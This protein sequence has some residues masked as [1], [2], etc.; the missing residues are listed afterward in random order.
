MVNLVTTA[1]AFKNKYSVNSRHN[2]SPGWSILRCLSSLEAGCWMLFDV[3]AV[4]SIQFMYVEIS[5]I[6][7]FNSVMRAILI[8]LDGVIYDSKSQIKGA[9]ETISWLDKSSIPYL[10]VTNTCS[11]PRQAIVDKL[12]AM[13]IN[14]GQDKI[15]TPIVA[16]RQWLSEHN[17]EPIA[18][19]LEPATMNEFSDFQV[20]EQSAE[21]GA[22][23]VL[24]GDIGEAWNYHSLNRALRL[25]ISEPKPELIALGM[26]RYWHSEHGLALDVGPF[27]K[28]LEFASGSEAIVMG[29]PASGFFTSAAELLEVNCGELLMI[30]DDLISDI[31]AAQKAGLLAAL[32]KTGKFMAADLNDEVKPDFII[33]SIA[34][35][36]ELWEKINQP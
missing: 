4:N 20:V 22:G 30:G 11:K 18:L 33:N 21:S 27:I 13:Q 2:W 8:D 15:L 7:G 32:V 14:V 6:S 25:L 29:K 17:V 5:S 3:L 35:L 24:I 28:A 34:D 12:S 23:A 19:F 31:Q 1:E 9:T 26:S 10:F 36:P 16:A